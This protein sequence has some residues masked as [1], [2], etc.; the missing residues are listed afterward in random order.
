MHLTQQFPAAVACHQILATESLTRIQSHTTNMRFT[1]ELTVSTRTIPNH[2]RQLGNSKMLD[3]L[4]A[5][6]A[7]PKN[8]WSLFGGVHQVLSTKVFWIR[9]EQRAKKDCQQVD[10]PSSQ[11]QI[12]RQTLQ[13]LNELGYETLL[14]PPFSPRTSC[15]PTTT[16][17][18]GS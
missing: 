10:D 3:K 12:T 8:V 16:F 17:Q 13:E 14:H 4:R 6:G 18:A 2:L 5:A 9:V 11:R 15:L 7:V 1:E